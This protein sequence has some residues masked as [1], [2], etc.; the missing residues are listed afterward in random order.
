MEKTRDHHDLNALWAMAFKQGL[1][2]PQ[3][4]PSWADCLGGLHK[5][6]YYLRYSGY[7]ESSKDRKSAHGIVLLGA[8]PMTSELAVLL[9]LVRDNLGNA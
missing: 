8:E 5:W 4:P 1:R 7:S 6:P 9:E 2:V 3:S